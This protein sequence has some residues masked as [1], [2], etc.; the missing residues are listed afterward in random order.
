MEEAE[1]M[2]TQPERIEQFQAEIASMQL[3]S[4]AGAR[5]RALLR[6]GAVMMV[7]GVIVSAVAYPMSHGTTEALAQRDAIVLGLLGLTLTVAGGAVFLRYS[8]V[9]F[10]R[11]WLARFSYEQQQSS[12]RLLEQ[13]KAVGSRRL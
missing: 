3:K 10:M 11:F 5:D 6:L 7:I 1:R 2:N 8:L 4:P 13:V 9:Q 12:E